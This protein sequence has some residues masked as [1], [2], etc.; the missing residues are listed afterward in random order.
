M[1]VCMCVYV[2]VNGLM[3]LSVPQLNTGQHGQQYR[4]RDLN[5]EKVWIQGLTGCNVTVA[6]VDDGG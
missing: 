6:F 2:C 1:Y 3:F 5:I 4:N